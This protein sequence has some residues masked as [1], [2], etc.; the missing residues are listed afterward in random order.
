MVSLTIGRLSNVES[1]HK[2]TIDIRVLVGICYVKIVGN[3]LVFIFGKYGLWVW[4]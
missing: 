3:S 2:V 1:R 4:S